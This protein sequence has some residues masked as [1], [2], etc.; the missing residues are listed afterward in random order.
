MQ[1]WIN[2]Y[3]TPS[4]P[5]DLT[6]E[7][8]SAAIATP[9]VSPSFHKWENLADLFIGTQMLQ[10]LSVFIQEEESEGECPKRCSHTNVC[11]VLTTYL[12]FVLER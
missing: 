6:P 9:T 12:T 7:V 11:I 1:N 8:L 3:L 2:W 4:N 5:R 10:M